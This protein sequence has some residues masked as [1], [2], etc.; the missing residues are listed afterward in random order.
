MKT[1]ELSAMRLSRNFT[2]SEFEVSK[3]AR[4]LGIDNRVPA[5]L[6]PRVKAL[7]DEI[8]QPM[9]T[10]IEIPIHISSGYRC[11]KVNKVNHGAKLSQ[12]MKGEAADIYIKPEESLG[13][14]LWDVATLIVRFLDFDQL[15]WEERPNGSRW[16][17][18]S[19]TTRRPNRRQALRTKDGKHYK[20]L[21]F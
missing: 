14:S 13:W 5:D 1:Q 2:L 7:V 12:H 6:V 9:R 16:I 8:L 17:H 10:R 4:E 20:P 18:V 19:Y 15:I 21:E 11:P 3:T